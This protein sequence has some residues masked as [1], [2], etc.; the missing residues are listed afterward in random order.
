MQLH[1]QIKWNI[2]ILID[3]FVLCDF[4]GRDELMQFLIQHG[5][6]YGGNIVVFHQSLKFGFPKSLAK[7]R[8]F[9]PYFISVF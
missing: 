3:T 2:I 1:T 6:E 7:K 8:L 4:E 5:A 9:H